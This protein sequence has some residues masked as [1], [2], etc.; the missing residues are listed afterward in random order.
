MCT[1]H[2]VFGHSSLAGHVG[3]F[4][5]LAAVNNAAVDVGVRTFL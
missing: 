3:G 5:L 1:H 2:V 4:R